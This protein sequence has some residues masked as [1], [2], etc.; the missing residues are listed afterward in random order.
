MRLAV[1]IC[2]FS[3]ILH[4]YGLPLHILRDLYMSIRSFARRVQ[5]LVQYRRATANMNERYPDATAEDLR[6]V[7]STCIICREEMRQ[8]KRL[9]C[10]HVFHIECLRMWLERQQTCPTCRRSVF[11]QPAP[12][13][14][15]RP[16]RARAA[17]PLAADAVAAAAHG[18][19]SESAGR[20]GTEANAAAASASAAA[21]ATGPAATPFVVPLY[22]P[23]D[24]LWQRSGAEALAR[25]SHAELHSL[26]RS[27]RDRTMARIEFLRQLRDKADALLVEASLYASLGPTAMAVGETMVSKATQTSALTESE[28]DAA[29]AASP[30]HMMQTPSD[31]AAAAAPS[32]G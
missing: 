2:F 23:P 31:K 9:P 21:S 18:T 32:H 26:E 25:L 27:E 16:A 15:T 30:M 22:I 3:V 1:Y 8:A 14:A 5:D 20:G 28:P 11:D 29:T 7:D 19:A 24:H 12:A 10:G 4:Y 6:M 17:S 13:Q